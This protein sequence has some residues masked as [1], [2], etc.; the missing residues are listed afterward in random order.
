[1]SHYFL[2]HDDDDESFDDPKYIFGDEI[3][4]ICDLEEYTPS[5]AF[6]YISMSETNLC[7]NCPDIPLSDFIKLFERKKEISSKSIGEIIDSPGQEYHFHEVNLYQK[8]ELK[9][10]LKE[11]LKTKNDKVEALPVVYQLAVYTDNKTG[12]APRIMGFFHKKG[13]FHLL[14]FDY[15]HSVYPK[16]K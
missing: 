1:M 9:E 12:K 7:F 14:W 2:P 13:I 3:K 16:K 4:K 6:D 11:L 5:F 8:K 15:S 10:R